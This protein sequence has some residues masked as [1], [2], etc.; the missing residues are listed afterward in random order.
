MVADFLGV[1][2]VS[3]KVNHNL[4][5]IKKVLQMDTL[6]LFI[7]ILPLYGLVVLGYIAAHWGGVDKKSI[8]NLAIYFL[9]P[10]VVFGFIA[11]VE[12]RPQ[13]ALLPLV[14]FALSTAVTLMFL[15]IGR[16]IY[17][18]NRANLLAMITGTVN[19]G[20]FGFP[21]VMLLFDNQW[22]GAYTLLFLGFVFK[23]STVLYYIAARGNFSVRDSVLKL[24]H[25]PVLYAAIAGL[26]VNLAGWNLSPIALTYFGHFKG[27]Y[28]VIGMMILG[29][30]LPR[31]STFT[32]APRFITMSFIGKFVVWPVFAFLF[33]V[34]DKL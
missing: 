11:Q 6:S 33:V 8:A 19:S 7:N 12:L 23:Q 17:P 13:F 1:V 20:Y 18:D 25:F 5:F 21:L 31:V 3:V 15:W 14:S 16:K 27:A 24:L 4:N 9:V 29:A 10:V 32:F 26:V 34:L 22:I 28:V 2:E 30:S